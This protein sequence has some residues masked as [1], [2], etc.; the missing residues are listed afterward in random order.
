MTYGKPSKGEALERS[1]AAR[2][3]VR[4]AAAL[5]AAIGRKKRRGLGAHISDM[6]SRGV[7]KKR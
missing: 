5:A 6:L 1:L 2:P 3:G 7:F 4:N